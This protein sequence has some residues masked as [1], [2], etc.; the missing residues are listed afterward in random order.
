VSAL[1]RDRGTAPFAVG[2]AC[3]AA[4]EAAGIAIAVQWWLAVGVSAVLFVA[5]NRRAYRPRH[6]GRNLGLHHAHDEGTE[7]DPT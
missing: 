5:L 4:A 1:R 7:K 3:A 6:S 2:A